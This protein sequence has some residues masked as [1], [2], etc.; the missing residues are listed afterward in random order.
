MRQY[1][2]VIRVVGLSETKFSTPINLLYHAQDS[3]FETVGPWKL[4]Q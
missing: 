3:D 1:V 4:G 2:V